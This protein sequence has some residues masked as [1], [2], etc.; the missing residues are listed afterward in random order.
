L[1]L[2]V[3]TY[4]EEWLTER[5]FH[6][7]KGVPLSLNPLFVKHDDQNVGLTNLLTLA[8]RFVTLIGFVVPGAGVSSNKTRRNWSD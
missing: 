3:L 8:V 1:D 5:S 4:H 2:A 7:L 6:R